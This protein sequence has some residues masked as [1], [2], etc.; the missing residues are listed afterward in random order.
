MGGGVSQ[1]EVEIKKNISESLNKPEKC[2]KCTYK[3]RTSTSVTAV[4][5]ALVQM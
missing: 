5:P 2:E 3:D 4:V 1:A